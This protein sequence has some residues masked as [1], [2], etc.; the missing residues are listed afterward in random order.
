MFCRRGEQNRISTPFFALLL[1]LTCL[2][3]VL[4]N[5]THCK[6][7]VDC[8]L[9]VCLIRQIL[10]LEPKTF[11]MVHIRLKKNGLPSAVESDFPGFPPFCISSVMGK[12]KQKNAE[13]LRNLACGMTDLFSISGSNVISSKKHLVSFPTVDIC[14]GVFNS[15]YFR[16]SIPQ[17][18]LTTC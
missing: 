15:L 11:R 13:K 5:F 7:Y 10:G 14:A 1:C 4:F 17:H 18:L 9:Q 2:L 6:K 8:L 16:V 12:N 3:V